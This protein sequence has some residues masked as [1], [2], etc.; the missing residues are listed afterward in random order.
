M[1]YINRESWI[2]IDLTKRTFGY[3]IVLMPPHRATMSL[4]P[5]EKR[6]SLNTVH[7]KIIHK[8]PG[9]ANVKFSLMEMQRFEL[10]SLGLWESNKR[11]L[12]L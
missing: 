9:F 2:Y 7:L 1:K 8:E 10:F 11:L 4:Y 5:Y 12:N 6:Y 3:N